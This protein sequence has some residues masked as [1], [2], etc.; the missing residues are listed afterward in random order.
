[1]TWQDPPLGKALPLK[2][3]AARESAGKKPRREE[4]HAGN[5]KL[6][7]RCRFQ[8]HLAATV[9][10]APP[11]ACFHVCP[12]AISFVQENYSVPQTAQSTA[13]VTVTYPAAQLAGDTNIVA[14]GWTDSTSTITSVTDTKGNIYSPAIG[15]TRQSGVQ[16]QSIYVA[17]NVLAAAAGA[18]T[19][20]VVFSARRALAGCESAGVSRIGC[21]V[22]GGTA[23]AC[24]RDGNDHQL[25]NPDHDER[26]R[27]AVRGDLRDL[28]HEDCRN[29]VYQPGNHS[30]RRY[31]DGPGGNGGG[32][33]QRHYHDESGK[34]GIAAGGPE[35]GGFG[36][37]SGDPNLYSG[38]RGRIRPRKPCICR[39]RRH[40]RR[41]T[42]H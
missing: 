29:G 17:K 5:V 39:I 7:R 21:R 18:N 24:H 3:L 32:E 9:A 15:P 11:A 28:E 35:G 19:V 42:T 38:P 8:I 4:C 6:S 27:L 33:L 25:G 10:S 31:C 41:S 12:A 40:W 30:G 23:I 14:I 2:F 16:S 34:L 13:P 36:G 26:Q 20:T 1:M 37:G 22:S